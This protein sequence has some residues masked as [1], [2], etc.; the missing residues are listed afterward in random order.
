MT[1]QSLPHCPGQ[2]LSH[3][4]PTLFSHR[5]LILAAGVIVSTA[6]L[7]AGTPLPPP[8]VDAKNPP[9]QFS[10]DASPWTFSAGATVRSI[11]AD[12]HFA[13]PAP[14]HWQSFLRRQ[15]S[16]GRG[17]V[18][19]FNGASPLR[20]D[21]GIVGPAQASGGFSDFGT[22]QGVLTSDSQLSPTGRDLATEQPIFNAAFHSSETLYGYS[23]NSR[24]R[25]LD[26]SDSDVGVG[27]YVNLSYAVFSTPESS[28]IL[29][30]GWS[31][32]QTEHGTGPSALGWQKVTTTRTDR[33][34][35]YNYDFFTAS[36]D[37]P[38]SYPYT[39]GL[40]D[41]LLV[42][43]A[44]LYD[45]LATPSPTGTQS[46]RK[47]TR[48]RSSSGAVATFVPLAT[49][50]LDVTLNEI[51]FSLEYQRRLGS[52]LRVGIAVGPTLNVIDSDFDARVAWHANG[53]GSS[54]AVQRWHDSSTDV[55]VGAMGQVNVIFDLTERLFLE[56]HSSYRWVDSVDVG[57]SAASVSIDPSSWES[58]LGIGFRF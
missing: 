4:K 10:T 12:F 3:M 25:G 24:L 1:T 17:D 5:S 48:S 44:A 55:R 29:N 16:S 58:G 6:S 56:A 9:A 27:P 41:S 42:H 40:P 37:A 34:F 53:G 22:A 39:V 31:F 7:D 26:A 36:G 28:V 33:E 47:S 8:V 49:S 2:R 21:D 50:Q 46:P 23:S 11:D 15:S 52:R 43:D 13:K 57:G 32:V 35:T 20:Y 38:D 30:L 18:G 19:F 51:V 54:V 45:A 14:L